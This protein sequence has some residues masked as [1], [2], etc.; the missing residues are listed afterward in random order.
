MSFL[1][2]AFLAVFN[3]SLTAV[4]ILL[5]VMLLRVLLKKAPRNA[6]CFLWVLVAVRLVCPFTVESIFS[7][8]PNAR[9]IA[10]D[11]AYTSSPKIDSGFES[12]DRVVNPVFTQTFS[13]ALGDSVNPLQIVLALAGVVWIVGIAAFLIYTAVCYARLH[14]MVAAR[15]PI[16]DGVFLCDRISSPF[17]CGIFRPQIYLPSS[18][19]KE[20]IPFII[21]HERA[22]IARCDFLFKPLGFLILAVYWFQPLCW[23][24]Y[25]MFCRDMEFACDERVIRTLDFDSRRAYAQA[26]LNHSTE[27]KISSYGPLAFGEVSVKERV[28][29]ILS[30][31]KPTF[32]ILCAVIL[33]IPITAV[34]L[35]TDPF[36]TRLD[37]RLMVTLDT[38]IASHHQSSQSQSNYAS[39]DYKILRTDRRGDETV[40]YAWV[41]YQEYSMQNGKLSKDSG[42][43]TPTVITVRRKN[44]TYTLK[45]YWTPR[46]GSY[47]AEDIK[48][49]FPFTLRHAALDGSRYFKKMEK[50]CRRLAEEYFKNAA[51]TDTQTASLQLL[52]VSL[53]LENVGFTCE[54]IDWQNNVPVFF[55]HLQNNTAGDLG[56]GNEFSVYYNNERLSSDRVFTD[57]WNLM[58]S[59]SEGNIEISLYGFDL[60][61]EGI[62]EIRKDFTASETTETAIVRFSLFK[63]A[64]RVFTYREH[65][66]DS[67]VLTLLSDHR[68]SFSFSALSSYLPIGTYEENDTEVVLHTDDGKYTY[69]FRKKGDTLIFDAACSS[70]IP[71]FVYSAGGPAKK[72]VPDGAVFR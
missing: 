23:I 26:L 27:R 29:C 5:A 20:Q 63:H 43:Y 32:W 14:R 67:P 25:G 50:N 39:I 54:K 4:W 69:T 45:E 71:V 70:A 2:D 7:R 6:V 15:L 46:D 22:H 42:A 31:K 58:F 3:R 8:I 35:L 56:W 40:V 11:I 60:S 1:S 12:I 48:E 28:K 34:C 17:L 65:E 68:F 16:G 30:Y 62:Y 19:P 37:D 53:P 59:G 38:A 21:A 36:G 55:M 47:Y 72:A 57:I 64:V 41:L 49:K 33:A 44:G 18:T 52:E 66:Y 9:P 13:P 61:R 24:A 51:G 10:S